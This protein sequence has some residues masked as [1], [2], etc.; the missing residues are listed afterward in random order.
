M[1]SFWDAFQ[2]Y[3]RKKHAKNPEIY[4]S[5]HPNSGKSNTW[6]AYSQEYVE[7]RGDDKTI[8]TKV[9]IPEAENGMPKMV[10]I[11]NMSQSEFD[12]LYKSLRK[13][14]PDNRVNR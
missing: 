5:S 3:N 1:S 9:E 2:V 14:E 4:G 10:D 11:S 7:K 6:Y 8:P 13:G 12:R